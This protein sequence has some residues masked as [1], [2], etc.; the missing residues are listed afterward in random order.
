MH[1]YYV[2]LPPIG[3]FYSRG[4]LSFYPPFLLSILTHSNISYI[5]LFSQLTLFKTD[6][7][8]TLIAFSQPV[9]ATDFQETFPVLVLVNIFK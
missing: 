7:M 2:K 3:K 5:F 1:F 4:C 8:L 9:L 6:L